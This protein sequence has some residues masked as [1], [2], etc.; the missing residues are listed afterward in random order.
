MNS[1]TV[2]NANNINEA[3]N[4]DNDDKNNMNGD[5]SKL[6]ED[7]LTE[8]NQENPPGQGEVQQDTV[9]DNVSNAGSESQPM[10][11]SSPMMDMTP[12]LDIPPAMDVEYDSDENTSN[13]FMK[14]IKK[15]LIVL[16]LCYLLFNPMVRNLL[17]KYL[18]RVF[19]ESAGRLVQQGQVLLLSLLVAVLFMATNLLE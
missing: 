4:N 8:L 11:D 16:C 10:V 12:D 18:P 5:D 14:K 2:E 15:P 1:N 17:A 19:S 6:V 9:E 7:I 13:S 3:S